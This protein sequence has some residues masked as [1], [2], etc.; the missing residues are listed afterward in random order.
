MVATHRICAETPWSAAPCH[1]RFRALPARLL[2]QREIST[3][4]RPLHGLRMASRSS[5]SRASRPATPPARSVSRQR[6]APCCSV[7]SQAGPSAFC[8]LDLE[9]RSMAGGDRKS[10]RGLR[11][12]VQRRACA[13]AGPERA[14][15]L[16]SLP[17]GTGSHPACTMGADG[18]EPTREAAPSESETA[19]E[20]CHRGH[21]E[22]DRRRAARQ[23]G[24]TITLCRLAS[25]RSRSPDLSPI[26]SVEPRSCG[27][28]NGE[29][30]YEDWLA[31][32]AGSHAAARHDPSGRSPGFD[33]VMRV[34]PSQ[35]SSARA[36]LASLR[37]QTYPFWTVKV[38]LIGACPD[39]AVGS[40]AS[41]IEDC[42]RV[43]LLHRPPNSTW[44]AAFN[45]A[46]AGAT[47]DW[48]ACLL[49]GDLSR[50]RCTRGSRSPSRREPRS[51]LRLRRP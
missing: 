31:W 13:A 49:P 11:R 8:R 12:R 9:W 35:L 42:E 14:A 30:G 17:G 2:W 1:T 37:C 24:S 29:R 44:A 18:T 34:E 20:E 40:L 10:R 41:V 50:R 7:L 32:T 51:T 6:E 38:V 26:A 27:H 47:G 23:P 46:L 15:A 21:A 28:V 5:T 25:R 33:L 48:L 36:T 16:P 3:R 22:A 19:L 4:C 39:E 43:T 45:L